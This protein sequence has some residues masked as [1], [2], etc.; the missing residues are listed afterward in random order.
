MRVPKRSRTLVKLG[1]PALPYLKS[2]SGWPR[3]GVWQLLEKADDRNRAG[4]CR[5]A[6]ISFPGRWPWHCTPS[7]D[8]SCYR[9]RN[10]GWTN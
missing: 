8:G 9:N 5:R 6:P 3:P 7:W 4:R 2:L 1:P 10:G